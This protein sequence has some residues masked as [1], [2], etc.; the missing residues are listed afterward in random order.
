M[1]RM[2]LKS[3]SLCLILQ[4]RAQDGSHLAL[5]LLLQRVT[6]GAVEGTGWVTSILVTM[7]QHGHSPVAPWLDY[8]SKLLSKDIPGRDFSHTRVSNDLE[9]HQCD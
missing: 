9:G 2:A 1:H 5:C 3:L 4:A 7:V 8:H 6:R